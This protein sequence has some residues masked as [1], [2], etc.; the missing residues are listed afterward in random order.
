MDLGQPVYISGIDG[1][2]SFQTS[3]TRICLTR[4]MDRWIDNGGDSDD[5]YNSLV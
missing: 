1:M 2:M 5:I 4:I 3:S